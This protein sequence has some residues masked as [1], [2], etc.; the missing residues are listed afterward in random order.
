MITVFL[1]SLEQHWDGELVAVIVSG[2]EV[3]GAA[4]LSDIK[5]VGSMTIT[6]K[7]DS[8][9]KPTAEA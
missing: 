9:M 5:A 4:A 2:Y 1:R 7:L 8:A 6:Q 3:D